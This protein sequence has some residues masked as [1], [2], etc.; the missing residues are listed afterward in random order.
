M[1]CMGPDNRE[2]TADKAFEEIFKLLQKKY[3]I[4]DP[5]KSGMMF[6]KECKKAKIKLKKSLR[7]LFKYDSWDGF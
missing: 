2:D 4:N 3:G 7:E 1:P 6:Q 5:D